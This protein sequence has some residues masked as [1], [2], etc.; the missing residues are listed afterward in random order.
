MSKKPK[1][2]SQQLM[3]KNAKRNKVSK[4]P[5]VRY[6]DTESVKKLCGIGKKK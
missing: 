6:L 2:K 5:G 3:L 4:T 1:N